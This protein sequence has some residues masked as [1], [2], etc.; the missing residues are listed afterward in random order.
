MKLNLNTLLIVLGGLGVFAPD[1][2][3]VATWLAS[4]HVA[5]LGSVVRGLGLLAA[6]CSAAPLVVPRLRAFLALLGLATPP[7]AR[8]PWIPGKDDVT[9][10]VTS[11]LPQPSP[12]SK[13]LALLVL[14]GSLLLGGTAVAQTPVPQ[15]GWC[16]ADGQTCIGPSLAVTLTRVTADGKVQGGINPGV[17]YGL[18]RNPAEAWA[19]GVDGCLAF[20]LNGDGLGANVLSPALLFKINKFRAGVDAQ[21]TQ[22]AGVPLSRVF[23]FVFGGGFDIQALTQPYAKAQATEAVRAARAQ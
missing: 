6:F 19:Y 11:K 22:A 16:S 15:L 5:W 17:C 7:G 14:A 1:I 8:A 23:G 10:V 18:T 13:V 2:A 21:F 20:A 4:M 3:A 12:T 9:P